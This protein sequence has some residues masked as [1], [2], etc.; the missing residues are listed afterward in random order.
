MCFHMASFWYLFCPDLDQSIFKPR[1]TFPEG[2]RICFHMA[3]FGRLSVK[4]LI[5]QFS[6][7]DTHPKSY[8]IFASRWLPLDTFLSR[9][10]SSH[11]HTQTT[12][13]PQNT[14]PVQVSALTNHQTLHLC[15]FERSR[16]TKHY[17]CACLSVR[18]PPNTT[19]VQVSALTRHQTLHLCKFER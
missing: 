18:E 6:N 1:Y 4:I 11:S 12:H 16:T 8:G 5:M 14:T 19:P 15:K 17:T 2:W 13:E 10:G 7:P 9:S 3:S